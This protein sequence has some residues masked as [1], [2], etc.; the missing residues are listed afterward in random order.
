M[1]KTVCKWNGKGRG[2]LEGHFGNTFKMASC[3]FL[4]CGWGYFWQEEWKLSA[5]LALERERCVVWLYR[6]V[7]I[8]WELIKNP[9]LFLHTLSSP[10]P[11]STVYC[12]V[13]SS[14]TVF[15]K[16]CCHQLS[17]HISEDFWRGYISFTQCA[18]CATPPCQSNSFWGG[19]CR[20]ILLLFVRY[21]PSS[22]NATPDKTKG[23][24]SQHLFRHLQ[25]SLLQNVQQSPCNLT[26]LYCCYDYSVDWTPQ[27]WMVHTCTVI[28]LIFY[29]W[30]YP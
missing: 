16:K 23:Y 26:S 10:T 15:S 27:T 13:G 20:A 28:L 2:W 19:L 3:D 8:L 11:Y 30:L 14:K 21:S 17:F 9:M 5:L 22:G 12:Y 1:P 18:L 4:H 7:C 6:S 29:L 25:Y 24:A